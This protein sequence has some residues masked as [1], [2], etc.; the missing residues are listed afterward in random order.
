MGDVQS[1]IA[2]RGPDH[3]RNLI[4]AIS[5]NRLFRSRHTYTCI[6][7]NLTQF[8]QLSEGRNPLIKNER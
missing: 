5:P 1:Y 2:T 7:E 3:G 8:T 4:V 6:Q